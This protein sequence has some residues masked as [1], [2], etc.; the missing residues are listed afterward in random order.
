V[1]LASDEAASITG[2]VFFVYGPAINVLKPWDSG[3]LIKQEGKW[4]PTDL[5]GKLNENFPNGIAPEGMMPMLLKAA[6]E[7]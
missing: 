7:G 3:T 1:A 6:G 2:Q 4:D 5:V